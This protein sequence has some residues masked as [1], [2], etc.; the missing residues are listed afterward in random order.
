[1]PSGSA[2]GRS[3]RPSSGRAIS[4]RRVPGEIT[5]VA[6]GRL[7]GIEH[8]AYL[9]FTKGENDSGIGWF[10]IVVDVGNDAN[11]FQFAGMPEA[12]AAAAKGIDITGGNGE[13]I[14]WQPDGGMRRRSAKR[15]DAFIAGARELLVPVIAAGRPRY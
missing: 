10:V 1:M 7:E 3:T 2:S 11:T 12:D 8:D 13:Q 14:V 6:T 15:C 9:L 4:T 5:Q